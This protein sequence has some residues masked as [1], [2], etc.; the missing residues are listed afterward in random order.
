MMKFLAY[1]I[2]YCIYPFS[3]LVPRSK[4]KWAFGSF[5]GAFNDNAKYLFIHVTEQMPDIDCAWLSVN[6]T[7]V[8]TIKE[9][10]LKA[11]HV[12]SPAGIWFALR[13]KCWFFNAYSSDIMFCLSGGAKLVNL[14]HGLPLKRIEFDI[15]SGILADR[16][17][18]KTLKERY[19]HP[20]VFKRPDYVVS[21]TELFSEV[22]ARSF[23][24]PLERC[25][26]MGL[27]RNEIL[28]WPEEKR[29]TFIDRYEPTETLDLIG[30]MGNFDRVF[31]YMPTW[32]DSQNDFV[33][34]GFDFKSMEEVLSENNALLLI[35]PHANTFIDP[36]ILNG[37]AHIKLLP[38]TLD[39]Y[40]VLPY[41]DV[42][43]TD[44]SSVMYD[45]ILMEKK[46]VILYL[47][48]KEEYVNE[49]P[50]IWSFEDMTYGHRACSFETLLELVGNAGLCPD[51]AEK[52]VLVKKCWGE[53]SLDTCERISSFFKQS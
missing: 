49:R 15:E 19:F 8:R 7:T 29:R 27:A 37:L 50:F 10:G 30:Q 44:Y 5:R 9:K 14:W 38:S 17:V 53:N 45:Y 41:T 2:C 3:F 16:F 52:A 43:I 39:I 22:F 32:R 23:R 11:Y 35:K 31:V 40:P 6:R 34:A 1:L 46:D 36:V 4:K 26:N 42:L 33:T 24:I 48:D 21:S 13:A 18:K 25:L 20:E 28:T 51:E 47:F 12:L